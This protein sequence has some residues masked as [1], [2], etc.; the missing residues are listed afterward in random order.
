MTLLWKIYN[1]FAS[2]VVETQ[3]IENIELLNHIQS[4]TTYMIGHYSPSVRITTYVCFIYE[5]RNLRLQSSPNDKSFWETLYGNFIYSQ[6]LCQISAEGKSL[7]KYLFIF[8]YWWTG[9]STVALHPINHSLSV[10]YRTHLDT[11]IINT[12]FGQNY[13]SVSNTTNVMCV[14]FIYEWRDLQF[15]V[16]SERQIFEK[17]F[18]EISF[19]LKVFGRNLLRGSRRRNIL[20]YFV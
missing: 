20:S 12:T 3:G 11:Y 10:S 9:V 8:S 6:S 1:Y 19:A 2:E 7:K 16:D 5:W 15:K 4:Y 18:K 14:N 17:L 13:D